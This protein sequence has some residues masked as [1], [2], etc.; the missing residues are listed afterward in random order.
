MTPTELQQWLC[1]HGQAVS[2]DGNPGP[3]TRAAIVAAFT[4]RSAA[5][6]T[7]AEIAAFADR[8]GCE[9]KQLRAVS[10]V[11]SGGAAFDTK[12]R[13]K[14]LFERHLFHRLTNGAW[15]VCGFSN[16]KGGGYADDSW[17]KLSQAACR[18]ERAAFSSASW[19]KFQVLGMHWLALEYPSP[20]EMAHSTVTSEAAHYEMLA[21]YIEKNGLRP[22]LAKL[23]TD[24]LSC[25]DFAAGYNGPGYRKFD[26]DVKLARAMR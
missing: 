13:P 12:G 14:I 11:E 2:V 23:S 1:T 10:M 3:Q 5:A 17:E 20:I 15:S 26:Y 24:P 9:V 6:V 22:A 25:R 18:N 8:L 7:E 19:G 4:N 21:R 16:P